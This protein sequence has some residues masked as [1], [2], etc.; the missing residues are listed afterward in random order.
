MLVLTYAL[1]LVQYLA[2]VAEDGDY[3]NDFLTH[4]NWT[5]R[6]AVEHLGAWFAHSADVTYWVGAYHQ[7]GIA[8]VLGAVRFVVSLT[9]Y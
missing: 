4:F 2:A 8:F 6:A 1:A 7:L 3:R 5:Q 9:T